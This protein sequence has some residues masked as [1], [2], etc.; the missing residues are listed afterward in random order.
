MNKSRWI[1]PEAQSSNIGPRDRWPEVVG[2]VA[3]R[4]PRL[5][6]ILRSKVPNL[7]AIV[8]PNSQRRR[9]FHTTSWTPTLVVREPPSTARLCGRH[10]RAVIA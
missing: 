3:D 6:A 4:R 5:A 10:I 8:F 9:G 2:R 1:R 7:E